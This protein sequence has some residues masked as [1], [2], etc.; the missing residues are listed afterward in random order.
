METPYNNFDEKI[1]QIKSCYRKTFKI[2]KKENRERVYL[3]FDGVM[4]YAKV[5]VNGKEAGEHYGGYTPFKFDITDL[6]EYDNENILTVMVDSSESLNIPPFGFVIDYLT[7]GGIYRE[8]RL[9]QVNDISIDNAHIKTL[10][11]LS[12]NKVLDIDLFI[13][14]N[15]AISK[16]IQAE[17][18]LKDT[19][20]NELLQY[21]KDIKLTGENI[22]KLDLHLTQQMM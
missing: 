18:I 12:D 1:Y 4:A 7:Y 19:T 6:I 9:E 20:G 2:E 14:N 5:Y 13:D 11:V 8:V 3:H 17:F 15:N 16:S 21:K 22:Q 10:D